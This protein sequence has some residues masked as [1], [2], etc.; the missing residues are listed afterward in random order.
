MITRR[1]LLSWG[2]P[3]VLLAC[4]PAAAQT[5]FQLWG[6]ITFNR[7]KSPRLVYELDVEPKVAVVVPPGDP[8]WRNLDVT[9]A[10]EYAARNWLDLTGEFVSG[11]TKQTDDENS[12]ELTLRAGA[13]FHLLSRGL[14][15]IIR[16][17]PVQG[18][19][20]P[21]RRLVLRDYVRVDWRN[22]FYS[23]DTPDSSTW[24][25][26]NRLE[27]LFPLNRQKITD[28]GARYVMA[29]WEWFVPLDD[30][31]ERFAGR[32]RIRAG[33]GWRKDVHFRWQVLY[34]W[35]RSRDTTGEPFTT[36]Q[37]AIDFRVNWVF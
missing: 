1:G 2:L 11:W 37:Q 23:K 21:K 6:N 5:N 22:F 15:T 28:D 12:I 35:N 18:E 33:F 9:P 34:V 27:F 16:G 25:F 29:D 7:I 31:S 14:P 8:G 13:R 24:R 17:R 32:Q 3:L 4:S 19:L 10:V 20:P 30:P 26:R 36:S